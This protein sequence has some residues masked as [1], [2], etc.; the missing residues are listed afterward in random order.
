M[1]F[2]AGNPGRPRGIQNKTTSELRSLARALVDDPV[3]R[4]A[5]QAR[6][7]E[8]SAGPIEILLWHYAYGKPREV[9][10]IQGE[11][12]INRIVRVIVDEHSV[13]ETVE[14]QQQLGDGTEPVNSEFSRADGPSRVKDDAVSD[15]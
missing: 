11:L 14:P 6:L 1:T 12:S 10:E 5:L 2:T 15:D 7:I 3:Y 9:V 8:G 4:T 13:V